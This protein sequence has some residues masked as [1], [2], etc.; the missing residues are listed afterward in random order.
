MCLNPENKVPSPVPPPLASPAGQW[1]YQNIDQQNQS[2]HC[3][4]LNNLQ[5][6]TEM[7]STVQNC[8]EMYNTLQHSPT[9]YN[10]TLYSVWIIPSHGHYL[11]RDNLGQESSISRHPATAHCI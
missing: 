4:T 1:L 10:P 2:S 6:G 8:T 5:H 11:V 9:L 3:I 7:F